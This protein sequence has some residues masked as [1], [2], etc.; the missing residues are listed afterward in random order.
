MKYFNPYKVIVCEVVFR[1]ITGGV[2]GGGDVDMNVVGFDF[3]VGSSL[4]QEEF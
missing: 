3:E 1:V 4:E 2:V